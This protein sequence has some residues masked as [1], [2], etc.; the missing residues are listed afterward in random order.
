MRLFYAVFLPPEAQK[1]LVEA[2]KRLDPFKGWRRVPPH[3]LH[4][5]LLF[6][7]EVAEEEVAG[8]LRLGRRLARAIPPFTA[9]L[10]GTGYFPNEGSPRVWFA[11]V[12]GEGFSPL[13]EG[14][15]AGAKDPD[16]KPFV[17][18]ITLARKK[19]PAPRVGPVVFSLEFPVEEF[20]LVQSL[21]KPKGPE[22]KILE[23]FPLRGEHERGEEKS[24]GKRSKDD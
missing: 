7:G 14:L 17:P 22:Y 18:H 5:T 4:L 9:R 8:L 21:L 11:K 19:G 3:Q 15:R 12:E 16:P 2:Q 23:R 20:A 24:P 10:R 1:A 13:A 6:L